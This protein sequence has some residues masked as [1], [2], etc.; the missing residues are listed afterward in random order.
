MPSPVNNRARVRNSSDTANPLASDGWTNRRVPS[1]F[2]GNGKHLARA[3]ERLSARTV[4]TVKKPGRYADGKG[5]HLR[6]GVAHRPAV[7]HIAP[8]KCMLLSVCCF[9]SGG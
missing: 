5:L 9:G 2:R 8:P 6:I 7:K 3:A 1:V 4:Q